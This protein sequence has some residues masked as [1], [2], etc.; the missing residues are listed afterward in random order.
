MIKTSNYYI[1]TFFWSTTSK[2][3]NAIFGFISVPILLDEFGKSDYGILS[4]AMACNAYMYV[5]DLGMNVGAVKFYSQWKTEDKLDLLD[6]V[7]RTNITFYLFIALINV[8]L[9]LGCIFWGSSIF[10]ISA[11]K[12]SLLNSC[13]FILIVFSALN[14]VGAVF[15][16]LLV[17]NEMLGFA[18]K[19]QCVQVLLK[20]ALI[21]VVFYAEIPLLA[22]FF[23]FTLIVSIPVIPYAIEC[24]KKSLI[25][26][27]IPAFYFSDLKVVLLY[28]LS[29]FALTLL[30]VTAVQ[31]RPIILGIFSNNGD[32]AVAD[33]RIVEL[34]PAFLIVICGMFSSIFLPRTSSIVARGDNQELIDFANK[35]T[36]RTS[37]LANLLCVPF[38]LC[39]SE[40]LYA[41]VGPDYNQLAIW[42]AVWCFTVILQIHTTPGNAIVLAHGKTKPLV[43]VT[44]FACMLSIGVNIVLV[45]YLGLGAAVLS[46]LLYVLIIIAQYY[47]YYY[48]NI[49]H[50]HSLKMFKNFIIPTLL[51]LLSLAVCI[52]LGRYCEEFLS[53]STRWDTIRVCILKVGIWVWF[54]IFTLRITGVVKSLRGITDIIKKN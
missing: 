21:V 53:Y 52:A 26:T 48:T 33:F 1:S 2:I 37:L 3:L 4:I 32:L 40:V 46:Y 41:Y 54:Y 9:L 49:L 30:Q 16:Q 11:E 8:L 27:L 47:L 50:L 34:I 22:Y 35:W 45:P 31:S 18:M 29:I 25:K 19:V 13:F 43:V 51:A 24:R 42:L 12:V 6:R 17:A 5:L 28:S 7:V 15:Y 39:A 10:S 14:W 36:L 38:I 23:F 44:F 20:A